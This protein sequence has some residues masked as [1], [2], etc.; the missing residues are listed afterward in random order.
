MIKAL[1]DNESGKEMLD[2]LDAVQQDLHGMF[3]EICGL[4]RVLKP[5]KAN[6]MPVDER[7][8]RVNSNNKIKKPRK[9]KTFEK[10]RLVSNI[11]MNKKKITRTRP[12]LDIVAEQTQREILSRI[13]DTKGGRH[14]T[15][16]T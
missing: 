5:T 8:M 7:I 13:I 16:I 2:K 4:R 6:Q 10:R 14:G 3:P 12:R 15:Y 1:R 11:A 9:S